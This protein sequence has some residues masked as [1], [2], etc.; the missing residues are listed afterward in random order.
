MREIPSPPPPTFL[1]YRDKPSHFPLTP[2]PPPPRPKNLTH[3]K[4]LQRGDHSTVEKNKDPSHIHFILVKEVHKHFLC[5]G[6][7]TRDTPFPPPQQTPPT[8]RCY[9]ERTTPLQTKSKTLH[10]HISYLSR[11]YIKMASALATLQETSPHPNTPHP[12]KGVTQR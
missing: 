4:V 5:T 7:I 3:Q 10:T 12:S 6:N 1:T 11:R 2:L 9:K 8:T